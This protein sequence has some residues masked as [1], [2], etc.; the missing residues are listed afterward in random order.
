[1]YHSMVGT[2]R[3]SARLPVVLRLASARPADP[4]A[5]PGIRRAH[6]HRAHA[7]PGPRVHGRQLTVDEAQAGQ[8][9]Q[10]DA[11]V[12]VYWPICY[13][14]DY[15]P[16]SVGVDV[17]AD[18]GA[19]G[20]LR[21]DRRAYSICESDFGPGSTPSQMVNVV[22]K[23]G[24]ALPVGTKAVMQCLTCVDLAPGMQPGAGCDY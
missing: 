22:R 19:T 12:W 23:A 6:H 10:P 2:R 4:G 5:G 1:M 16:A 3:W 8:D 18:H 7:A 20:G 9:A 14:P 24:E 21:I 15:S 11:K 17:A 13:D